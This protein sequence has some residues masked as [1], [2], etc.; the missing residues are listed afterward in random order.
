MAW[1]ITVYCRRDCGSLSS[2]EL[3][4]GIRDDD[5]EAPAGVDYNTLAED[6]DVPEAL[7][8]PA[9]QHLRVTED[10]EVHYSADASAR[11][12]V[13]HLWTAPERVREEV[14]EAHE[15]RD[16][17]SEASPYLEE[18]RAVVGIE[19]GF[20]MLE[21]MGVVF[22]YEVARYLAQKYDGVIVDDDHRWQRIHQIGFTPVGEG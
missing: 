5:P 8:A 11:P 12:V 13:V 2:R 21:T 7:V 10:F 3:A 18:C 22:A 17:P 6:Y 16:A 4:R 19:L 15:V 9:L 1:W 14:E 20:S